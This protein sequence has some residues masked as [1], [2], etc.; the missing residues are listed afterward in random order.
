MDEKE[1]KRKRPTGQRRKSPMPSERKMVERMESEDQ[2][3]LKR[4]KKHRKTDD[5]MRRKKLKREKRK[6]RNMTIL[7]V[8]ISMMFIA[9]IM[10]SLFIWHRYGP[11][12]ET[13]DLS[14]YY[15]IT[16]ED[17]LAIIVN[18]NVIGSGGKVINGEAYI[19]YETLRKNVNSRFYLDMHEQKLLYTLP[20]GNVTVL[21]E[22]K[23]YTEIN[24]PK[25]KEYIILTAQNDSVY[26]ALDFVKEYTDMDCKISKKPN[27]AMIVTELGDT[28]VAEIQKDT[29]VRYQAGRRSPILTS[30]SKSKMVTVI[31]NEGDWKKIRTEDGYIGYVTKRSLEKETKKTIARNFK[32]PEY[33]SIKKDYKINMTWNNVENQIANG[34]A[35]EDIPNAKGLTTISPTWFGIADTE[36]NLTSIGDAQYV[37]QAHDANLE[38]WVM[39]RDFHDGLTTA[40]E[41]TDV[42][43]YTSKREKLAEQVVQESIRLGV[44]GINLDFEL[45]D[46][47]CGRH[48]IQFVRELGVKC[49]EHGLVFSVDNYVPMSYN[50][51]RDYKEQGIVADYVI[52][53]G[54]DEHTAGSEQFGSVASYDYVKN[55]IE[56]M[57]KEIPK[58][59]VINAIPFYTRVWSVT[60]NG[61]TCEDHRMSGQQHIL[62]NAGVTAQWDNTTKQN[63]A[64]WQKDGITYKMW[65]EDA[66][67]IAEKMKLVKEKNLA[68]VSSW[69]LGYETPDVWDVIQSYMQ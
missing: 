28:T 37:K 1:Q 8:V 62:D 59:K 26:I 50:S 63:Y 5:I 24:V 2:P 48:F 29:Q 11:T 20:T 47:T 56:D 35:L 31:E 44:D 43:S 42:L 13:V 54:Y 55:G 22:S 23:D 45:I 14:K 46:E 34:L 12:K 57:L 10:V 49:R 7:G 25:S 30:I 18:N 33:T 27:R 17:D 9:A 38:V 67:S 64:E 65:L 32:E 36:G 39:F 3:K 52:M 6:R 66:Q 4:R 40:Q 69:A 53:M 16:S 60:N 61:F 21:A 15:G 41:V 19:E 68:G 58:D 51:F